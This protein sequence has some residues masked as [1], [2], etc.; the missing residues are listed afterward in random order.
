MS[1][2]S[3]ALPWTSSNAF[4]TSTPVAAK[5][6]KSVP[7]KKAVNPTKSVR[8]GTGAFAFKGKGGRQGAATA[9]RK[10]PAALKAMRKRVVLS[11]TNA[12]E[13]PD[14][15][16]LTA[17]NA[18][19][20]GEVLT[21]SNDAIDAL[22]AA[23]AFKHNQG[24]NLFRRPSTLVTQQTRDIASIVNAIKQDKSTRREIVTGEKG[25][26]KSVFGL[27]AMAFAVKNGWAVIHI[28]EGTSTSNTSTSKLQD[29]RL[30]SLQ[31]KNS[32]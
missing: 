22:R 27:Q 32:P 19:E 3:L 6:A 13:V 7:K 26:G 18:T 24:W 16:E 17:D 11:N 1:T 5:P 21:L 15:R 20:V 28:P 2:R 29:P 12:L 8:K 9:G 30:T 31:H 10:D 23:E 4:S 25:S 14:L